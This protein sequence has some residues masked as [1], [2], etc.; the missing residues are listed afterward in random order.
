[1]FDVIDT[2]PPAVIPPSL[3]PYVQPWTMPD[4]TAVT[5]RPIRPED[6]PLMIKFHASLSDRSVYYRYFQFIELNRRIAHERL[7]HICF[8]DNERDIALV[9]DYL[10]PSTR[11]HEILGVGRLAIL[12]AANEAEFAVIISDQWQKRGL[13]SELLRRLLQIGRDKKLSRITAIILPENRNMQRVC[14]KL[15]VS[16][17]YDR[18]ERLMKASIEL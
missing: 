5:I 9:V 18:K 17:R 8:I 4:G 2:P 11:A 7:M 3:W 6:E 1:M 13:G 15:G 10:N 16:L 12:P 14:E